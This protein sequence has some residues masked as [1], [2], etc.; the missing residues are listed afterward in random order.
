MR[1]EKRVPIADAF[2]GQVESAVTLASSCFDF[3]LC[4]RNKAAGREVEFG[5]LKHRIQVVPGAGCFVEASMLERVAVV[6]CQRQRSAVGNVILHSS[7]KLGKLFDQPVLE[8]IAMT[9]KVLR[10]F[11]GLGK[12]D[13]VAG[14]GAYNAQVFV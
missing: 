9:E 14:I 4:G 3:D 12:G 5:V 6:R 10:G 8:V 1:L 2:S 7:P 11:L 13:A